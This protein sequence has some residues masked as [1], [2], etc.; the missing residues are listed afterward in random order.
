MRK[1]MMQRMGMG[2]RGGGLGGLFGSSMYQGSSIN[3]YCMSCGAKHNDA[4]CPKCGSKIKK[5]DKWSIHSEDG[6]QRVTC[7]VLDVHSVD[8]V[9]FQATI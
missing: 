9:F 6:S 7:I 1:R 2:G 8:Q 3:Y 4:A 5:I